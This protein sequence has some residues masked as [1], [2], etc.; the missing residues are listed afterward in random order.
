MKQEKSPEENRNEVLLKAKS[1][2]LR[3]LSFSPRSIEELR[4]RLALKKYA[5]EIVAQVVELLKKQGFLNDKKF[6]ELFAQSRVHS[7][8]AGKKQLAFDLQKKGLSKEVVAGAMA[9][10]GDYDEK[11][12]AKELV[13]GRFQRMSG[14]SDEKKKARIFGFLKRRGFSNDVIFPVLR[15]LFKKN[16]SLF[17]SED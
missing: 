3:L 9:N 8:P 12:A 11:K 15:E 16:D 4:K 6:A 13:F 17:P 5:P 1:D 10:L 7:R 2:A 14:I